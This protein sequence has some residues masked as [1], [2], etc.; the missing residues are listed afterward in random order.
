MNGR[1]LT[2]VYFFAPTQLAKKGS[3]TKLVIKLAEHSGTGLVVV[4]GGVE[5]EANDIKTMINVIQVTQSYPLK[6]CSEWTTTAAVAA[7]NR[8][9]Y[10]SA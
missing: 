9:S 1:S 4:E 7:S 3:H 6:K 5:K 2:R 10:N 8:G